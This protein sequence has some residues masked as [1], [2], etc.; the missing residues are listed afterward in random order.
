MSFKSVWGRGKDVQGYELGS[1]GSSG[2][3][4]LVLSSVGV[5]RDDGRDSSSG[6][7][8]AS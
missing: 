8:L 3:V 2:L 7:G 5:A 4:L 1:D 6:R